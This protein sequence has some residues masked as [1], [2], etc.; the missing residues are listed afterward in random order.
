M[1]THADKSQENKSQSVA[2]G[3]PQKQG[4]SEST[5]QFVDN[6]PE[7]VTQRKLQEIANN[8]P[9][10]KQT[11]N[12]S[13]EQ[14]T[15]NKS[16]E[17]TSISS[18][19]SNKIIQAVWHQSP[20]HEEFY[21]WHEA[22]NG[23]RWYVSK[24]SDQMY[25]MMEHL[26]EETQPLMRFQKQIKPYGFWVEQG[27]IPLDADNSVVEQESAETPIPD[28]DYTPFLVKVVGHV[29]NKDG[30]VEPRT[31]N[32]DRMN[33]KA[34]EDTVGAPSAGGVTVGYGRESAIGNYVFHLT[35]LRNML[36]NPE[37]S[38][39]GSGVRGQ[40]LD[41]NFGGGSGGASETSEVTGD[42]GM[43]LGSHEHS[44]RRVA[45]TTS[46]TNL[47][48]YT[49]QRLEFTEKQFGEGLYGD[50]DLVEREPVLLRFKVTAQHIEAM[51]IDPM[52]PKDKYVRLIK[53]IAIS[54]DEMD[55][56]TSEGW[57]SMGV[58]DMD[59]LLEVMPRIR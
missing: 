32:V 37:S 42:E 23:M 44:K 5:F 8:S 25:F 49:N 28:R 18:N 24:T 50:F 57:V 59:T 15:Q 6:R 27:F 39:P 34:F 29:I 33:Q 11:D 4:S 16:S 17:R 19:V 53:D 38:E 12:Y 3:T 52:H 13:A 40:G 1:N 45:T 10:A 9:Q 35:T 46:Q 7:A 51:E 41:P 55:V 56:L 14:F 36:T 48:L 22:I 26:S 30:T 54:P 31:S 21:Q 47:K 2:N 58:I 43:I 20:F